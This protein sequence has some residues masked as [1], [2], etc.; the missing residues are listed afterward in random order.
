MNLFTLSK[1]GIV[2]VFAVIVL[3]VLL[4]FQL[5][6]A[7]DSNNGITYQPDKGAANGK[8]I[9]LIAGDQEYRSEEALSLLARILTKEHGFK[10]TVLF[11]VNPKT[12]Y[13]DPNYT[14]NVPGL[15][16]LRKADLMIIFTRFLQLPDSQ[17]KYVAEY[18]RAGKPVIGLRTAT[19]AFKFP[20]NSRNPYA[21]YSFDS[22]VGGWAGGFGRRV[23]GQ[24]WI[25][26]FGINHKE[27][28]RGLINA[29][30]KLENLSILRGVHD[31][32]VKTGTYTSWSASALGGGA[33][34][35]VWGQPTDGMTP[36]SRIEVDKGVMPIAWIREYT[37]DEGN[38]GRAFATTMGASVDFQNQG[39]RKLMVN[40]CYWALNMESHIKA[41][42]DAKIM[43]RFSPNNFGIGNFKKNRAP[44]DFK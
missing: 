20:Q 37:S 30:L 36:D 3:G 27:G 22:K 11:E 10:T 5:S 40:A 9:V 25:S 1:I 17:M 15:K 4:S 34:I 26:H 18:I 35:L 23:F 6:N 33:K 38:T 12:G 28:T 8:Y 19:H 21:K 42:D 7:Q 43:G 16:H 41:E 44:A 24:T 32:F 39:F 14:T 31:I 13:V 29:A 2:R